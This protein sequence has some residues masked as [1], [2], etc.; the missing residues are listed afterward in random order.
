MIQIKQKPDLLGTYASSLCLIHCLATPFVFIAQ[1]GVAACCTTTPE[2]WK[3]LDFIF[4][5]ISFFAIYWSTKTTTITW[6]KPMLWVSWFALLIVILNE[7]LAMF[8]LAEWVIYVPALALII[9]HLYN[10]KHC[11]CKIDTCCANQA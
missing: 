5:V 1:T 2:W 4:L 9:L 11:K 3:F 10:R 7:K 6:V 8:P